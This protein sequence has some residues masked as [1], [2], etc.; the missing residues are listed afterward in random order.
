MQMLNDDELQ[1]I[2]RGFLVI[3]LIWIG[4]LIALGVYIVIANILGEGMINDPDDPDDVFLMVGYVLYAFGALLLVLVYFI[5]KAI[6]NQQSFISKIS[7]VLSMLD[8]ST[9]IM[10]SGNPNSANGRY[11]G[12]ILICSGLCEAVGIYGLVLFILNGNFL[13][14]YL[15]VGIAI[16][17]QIYFRPKKQEL[18]D[19]ASQLKQEN[20][21]SMNRIASAN[22]LVCPKCKGTVTD[23]DKFC[24]YCGQTLK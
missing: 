2:D 18:I 11:M 16:A 5:R 19:L 4:L 7:G 21:Q 23:G 14:L 8:L 22:G 24:P 20:Q 3:K 9:L 6:T 10:S 15:L 13:D 1:S 17:A 12:G